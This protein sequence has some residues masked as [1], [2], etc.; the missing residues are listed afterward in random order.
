MRKKI[1]FHTDAAEIKGNKYAKSEYFIVN[2]HI[3]GYTV[4]FN[5]DDEQVAY[6]SI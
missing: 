5:I 6:Q 2:G 3:P 4:P 1:D